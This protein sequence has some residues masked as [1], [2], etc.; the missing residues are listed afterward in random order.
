MLVTP[1]R[2]CHRMG[3]PAC[4]VGSRGCAS[5]VFWVA[6]IPPYLVVKKTFIGSGCP[7]PWCGTLNHIIC[8]TFMASSHLAIA[9][10]NQTQKSEQQDPTL[11]LS[12]VAGLRTL[13]SS[14]SLSNSRKKDEEVIVFVRSN[15][16]LSLEPKSKVQ[17]ERNRSLA[18]IRRL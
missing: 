3:R 5:G 2:A 4:L 12:P 6:T 17:G 13:T 1:Q 10:Q 15:G 14:S 18:S 16:R 11:H 9:N 7:T 8:L